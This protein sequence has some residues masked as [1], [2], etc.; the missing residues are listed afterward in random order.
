MVAVVLFAAILLFVALGPL[1]WPI[2]PTYVDI[3]ARNQ[4]FSWSHPLGTDQ[5]GRDYFSRLIYG[6]RIS[7]LIGI[8]TGVALHVEVDEVD[9]P[10][11]TFSVA[12]ADRRFSELEYARQVA[13]AVGANSHEIVIDDKDFFGAL[14]RLL[15]HE[16]EPIA[17]P[18]SRWGTQ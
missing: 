6:A 18:S 3:R 17:H 4:G 15:W 2:E 11:E 10:I 7:L 16:D 9:R 13:R 12:F 14:P 8:A 5:L 1:L